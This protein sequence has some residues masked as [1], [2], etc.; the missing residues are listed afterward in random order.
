MK[1]EVIDMEEKGLI[2]IWMEKL[3]GKSYRTSLF[4]TI[5]FLAYFATGLQGVLLSTG[6]DMP[7]WGLVT[8]GVIGLISKWCESLNS[9]DSQVTG[10][11]RPPDTGL[12]GPATT[13]KEQIK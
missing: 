11:N 5:G 13:E 7:T 8:T 2:V 9:K 1:E 10:I 3:F 4:G 6:L 12:P